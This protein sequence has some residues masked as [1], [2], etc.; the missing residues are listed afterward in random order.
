MG[1]FQ[2]PQEHILR[3]QY[4]S[5]TIEIFIIKLISTNFGVLLPRRRG[6]CESAVQQIHSHKTTQHLS[7]YTI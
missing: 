6:D 4:C 7:S 5:A 3:H 1:T 2:F